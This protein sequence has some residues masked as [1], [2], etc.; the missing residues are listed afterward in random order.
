MDYSVYL[1]LGRPHIEAFNVIHRVQTIR[2]GRMLY[3]FPQC[4]GVLFDLA[5]ALFSSPTTAL[6]HHQKVDSN[7]SLL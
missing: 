5:V 7:S 6:A 3:G 2:M 4:I 1:P